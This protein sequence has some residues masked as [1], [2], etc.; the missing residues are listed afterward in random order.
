M[1]IAESC[2]PGFKP[3]NE[4][5]LDADL[6]NCGNGVPYN[7]SLVHLKNHNAPWRRFANARPLSLDRNALG[8]PVRLLTTHA[9]TV[10][11]VTPW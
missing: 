9:Q 5:D 6:R 7:E 11:L 2:V 1:Q 3:H 4:Y 8:E 10:R